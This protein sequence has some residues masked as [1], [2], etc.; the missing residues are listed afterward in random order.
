MTLKFLIQPFY[1]F[2]VKWIGE[3]EDP[4]GPCKVLAILNHTSL[5][6]WLYVGLV[7]AKFVWHIA[8]HAMAPVADVTFKRPIVGTFFKLLVPHTL[9]ISRQA[10]RTWKAVIDRTNDDVMIVILPEGRMKRA[11]GLDKDG[12]PM[13]VRGGIADILRA[14]PKGKML[15]AYSG[16][17]HHVQ[18]P[19][20]HMPKLFKILR[21]RLEEIDIPR[22]KTE[23]G[24]VREPQEFKHL[25]KED[26]EHRRDTHCQP[27][28]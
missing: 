7:P 11:D 21:L 19:G 18:V 28:R 27:A 15:I 16:G 5:F 8:G 26:L 22:Y 17:L 13:T 24:H 9:P 4:W 12:R 14:I 3:P 25:V 2:D 6:E 1:K 23:L 10:D 20:Q